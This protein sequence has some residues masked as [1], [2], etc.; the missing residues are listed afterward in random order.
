MIVPETPRWLFTQDPR[1]RKGIE[2]LNYIAWFNGSKERIPENAIIDLSG[3]ESIATAPNE[4]RVMKSIIS[5]EMRDVARK[6]TQKQN[7]FLASMRRLNDIF[8]Y[9]NCVRT[10]CSISMWI[11]S[12]NSH[13]LTL[14]GAQHQKLQ[15]LQIIVSFASCYTLGI[16][17]S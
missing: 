9:N 7:A 4:E 16:L 14:Y 8:N 10:I 2:V 5:L 3:R 6:E 12:I 15:P 1:S 11:C 13:Y 17:M